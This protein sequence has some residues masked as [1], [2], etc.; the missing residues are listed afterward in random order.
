MVGKSIEWYE[1]EK[2]EGRKKRIGRKEE[3]DGREKELK[4]RKNERKVEGEV[5]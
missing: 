1:L 3:K 2:R 5:K 4:L